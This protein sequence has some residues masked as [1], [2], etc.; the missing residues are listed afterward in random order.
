MSGGH[1]SRTREEDETYEE[2]DEQPQPMS[3][4]SDDEQGADDDLGQHDRQR[5][6]SSIAGKG[7]AAAAANKV[8]VRR[9]RKANEEDEKTPA[10]AAA[11]AASASSSKAPGTP[12]KRIG[13]WSDKE[14]LELCSSV[15]K[16]VQGHQGMLPG[17]VKSTKGAIISPQWKEIAKDVSK[18]VGQ[19]PD[20]AA[21]ACSNRWTRVRGELKV[22]TDTHARQ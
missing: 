8:E 12:A 5:A 1:S 2:D 3:G 16:W 17:A 14:D 9:K 4:A 7:A 11:A 6:T 19:T 15:L 22:R 18:L 13:K 10:G 21:R 20:A